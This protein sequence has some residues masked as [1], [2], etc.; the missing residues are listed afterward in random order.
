MAEDTLPKLLLQKY[1]KYGDTEIAMRKKT[2]GIWYKYT[3]KDYYENVKSFSLGLVSLGLQRGDKVC[4][5][6]E[7][8]PEWY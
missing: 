8:N 7:N 1:Q 4:I 6:G 5:L 2:L 3:W